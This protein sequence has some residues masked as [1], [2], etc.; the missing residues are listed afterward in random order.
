MVQRTTKEEKRI[1]VWRF[2]QATEKDSSMNQREKALANLNAL[3]A[4]D[5]RLPDIF[6]PRFTYAVWQQL[7]DDFP[8]GADVLPEVTKLLS[9]IVSIRRGYQ[10]LSC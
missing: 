4:D 3:R 5:A 2:R 6:D 8:N 7:A 10:R 9:R 1:S